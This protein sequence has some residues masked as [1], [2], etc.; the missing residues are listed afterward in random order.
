MQDRKIP[1]SKIVTSEY[2]VAVA[3]DIEGNCRVYDMIRLRKLCKISCRSIMQ[4]SK[5]QTSWRML[6]QAALI[7][8]SDAFMGSIQ[9]PEVAPLQTDL[10]ESVGSVGSEG[11][12]ALFIQA[13]RDIV[14]K[15]MYVDAP[16]NLLS[17]DQIAQDAKESCFAVQKSQ[18]YIYRLEDVIFA[19]F[20]H[21]AAYRK[22]GTSSKEV[23]SQH[24]PFGARNVFGKVADF[25]VPT[26]ASKMHSADTG[27]FKT[28]GLAS[29][30]SGD[31]ASTGS[32]SAAAG[33]AKSAVG[34]KLQM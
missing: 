28:G 11:E 34:F 1:V 27:G 21:L 17:L 15:D 13:E 30:K 5:Q 6:P 18:I 29:R 22:R 31:N 14:V 24:D 32:G 12:P 19:L 7:S 25:G 26:A 20:P 3:V 33:T 2:G 8:V 9:T 23:F 4:G 16:E 10:E